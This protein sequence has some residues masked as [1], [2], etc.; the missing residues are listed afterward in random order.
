M[1][2]N[3]INFKLLLMLFFFLCGCNPAVAQFEL[4]TNSLGL[5]GCNP[6]GGR[7]LALWRFGD[8]ESRNF[9]IVILEITD[10]DKRIRILHRLETPTPVGPLV[11]SVS[12]D[13]RFVVATDEW[14][15]AGITDRDLVIYDL[16]R[17]E[18][19][20]YSIHDFLSEKTISGLDEH[21]LVMVVKWCRM[22]AFDYD[23]MEFFPSTPKE[24]REFGFPYVVVDLLSR[25]VRVA[26]IPDKDI[27]RVPPKTPFFPN[28][29]WIPSMGDQPLSSFDQPLSV[30]F[31]LV[32]FGQQDSRKRRVFRLDKTSGDYLVVPEADWP[33]KKLPRIKIGIWPAACKS[34]GGERDR[35]KR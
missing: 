2:F 29:R 28:P 16:V 11:W 33:D 24:C 18:H 6:V 34:N 32:E 23:R 22:H 20:S 35:T 30:P 13:G 27:A 17:N 1:L 3:G 12:K 19:T 8:R 25:K 9:E 26:P 31:L 14:A 7:L 15:G 4:H 21:G 10:P 5:T